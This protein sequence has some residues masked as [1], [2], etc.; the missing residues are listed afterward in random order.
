VGPWRGLALS[1]GRAEG[2]VSSA[3]GGV[4]VLRAL[5]S[6]DAPTLIGA[7]AVVVELGGVLSHGAVL[8]REL[9]VPMVGDVAGA[10]G[11]LPLGARVGVDGSQ[12]RVWVVGGRSGL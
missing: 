10:V 9:G 3:P 1:P 7:A 5:D 2:V 6:G 12:G 11:A 4:R 8:A